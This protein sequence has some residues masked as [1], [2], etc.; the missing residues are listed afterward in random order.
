MEN[1]KLFSGTFDIQFLN[2]YFVGDKVYYKILLFSKDDDNLKVEFA[3][4]YSELRDLHDKFKKEVK[5]K[6]NYPEFPPKKLIGNSDEKFLSQRQSSL[7]SY[8]R[9]VLENKEFSQ[10]KSIRM[11]ICEVFKKNFKM[12][13]TNNNKNTS[14]NTNTNFNVNNSTVNTNNNNKN[15]ISLNNNI[16]RSN[17]KEN[18]ILEEKIQEKY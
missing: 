10:V 5:N 17:F 12:A 3:E 18:Y 14:S 1:N 6:K 7:Q 16:I 2:H 8:F 15:S 13:S 9:T 11:W 4:R